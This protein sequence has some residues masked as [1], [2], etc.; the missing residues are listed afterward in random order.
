MA[1][2]GQNRTLFTDAQRTL[3]KSQ[4][5]H[6]C[7][8]RKFVM[9]DMPIRRW[10]RDNGWERTG[11]FATPNRDPALAVPV[12]G[13]LGT[14]GVSKDADGVTTAVTAP[15][16]LDGVTDAEAYLRDRWTFPAEKWL[17]LSAVGN[18]WEGGDGEGGTRTY[19]QLK[20]SF[21]PVNDISEI[22]P[23]PGKL[24]STPVLRGRYRPDAHDNGWQAVVLADH[25]APYH[26]EALHAATLAMIA[27]LGPRKVCHIGDLA[28]YTNISKHA[29][30][31]A[32]KAAVDECTQAAVDILVG[33]RQAAPDAAIEILPGNHDIR[34]LSELLL[35][36]ERMA[37]IT[38]G[39]LPGESTRSPLISLPKLWRLEELGIH[40]TED[41]R[42]W[43]H[44]ELDIVPGPN[45][46][47]GVHGYLTGKDVAGRTLAKVGRSVIMGHTHGPEHVFKFNT[48]AQREQ[49]AMVVG[50]QCEVRGGKGFPTF[51]PRDTW[52][53]GPAVVTVYPSG[54]FDLSRARW[55]G[56]YL[57]FNG[58]R[59]SA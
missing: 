15:L 37:G 27:D 12:K 22:L 24:P 33:M 3:L 23:A 10:R 17:C 30:H 31:A 50:C 5:S 42:G 19:R 44:A 20:G 29:D 41:A 21:R 38:A 35:R 11:A 59:W 4:A 46:L 45:G 18:E 56:G 1:H 55:S 7:L 6:A 16:P 26:D 9:S 43:Q 14:P 13:P 40:M 39:R 34:P 57:H 28:D 32:I 2:G 47:A 54:E 51:A 36:A 8:A 58:E 53:Q 49:Q 25:Q 48:T 52:L